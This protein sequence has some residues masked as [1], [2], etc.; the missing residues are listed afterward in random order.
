LWRK[1]FTVY[2]RNRRV[3]N[4]DSCYLWFIPGGKHSDII[5]VSTAN[6]EEMAMQRVKEEDARRIDDLEAL[7]SQYREQLILA[8]ASI[9]KTGKV[10]DASDALEHLGENARQAR[11]EIDRIIQKHRQET[12]SEAYFPE[13]NRFLL[14][15]G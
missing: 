14:P 5:A 2:A 1:A 11:M 12:K 6:S 8:I 7:T 9:K 13:L 3:T 10:L 4:N 15:I